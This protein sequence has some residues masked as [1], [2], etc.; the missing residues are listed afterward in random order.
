MEKPFRY[1]KKI[2]KVGN[3]F[4]VVIPKNWLEKQM[5][6]MPIK[7]IDKMKIILEL[8]ENKVVITPLK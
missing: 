2:Q 1:Q 3:S 8:Y 7:D 5:K 4:G 6:K